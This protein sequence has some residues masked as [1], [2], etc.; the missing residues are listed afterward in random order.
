[1]AEWVICGQCQLKH[2]RRP[3]GYCP[4]CKEP[5]PS[6]A[7]ELGAAAS[8]PSYLESIGT[9]SV[10][11]DVRADGRFDLMIGALI[12]GVGLIVTVVTYQMA[13]GGGTYV[14]AT[15]AFIFGTLRMLRGVYRV[16]T[17]RPSK[18]WDVKL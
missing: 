6:S 8:R 4:R 13:T 5:I 9:H 11:D 10:A 12:V 17:G 18:F 15:G 14:V 16:V 7:L 2:A 1:M 3:D